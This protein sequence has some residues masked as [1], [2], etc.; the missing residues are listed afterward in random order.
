MDWGYRHGL[1]LYRHIQNPNILTTRATRKTTRFG[2]REAKCD[3]RSYTSWFRN[4]IPKKCGFP[5]LPNEQA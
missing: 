2:Q 5:V 1:G 4:C 3:A